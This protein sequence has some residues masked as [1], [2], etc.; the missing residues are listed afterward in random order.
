MPEGRDGE[1]APDA[2][3]AAPGAVHRQSGTH[4]VFISYASSDR[5]VADSVCAALERAGVNCW[6][7]PRD[8]TPGEF[9]SEAIVHAID[10]AKVVVL[11]LSQNAAVS[12][13]VLRE[14]ERASSKR[15]PVVSFRID[16]AP[17]PA[18]L[19]YFL[20]TSQWLDASAIG[21]ERALPKLVDAVQRGVAHTSDS[22][23]SPYGG[24]RSAARTE[25]DGSVAT[26]MRQRSRLMLLALAA[27]TAVALAYLVVDQFWLSKRVDEQKFSEAATPY[28]TGESFGGVSGP[29]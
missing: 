13:H 28:P 17:L 1:Q 21:V 22:A 25:P 29:G 18:A 6:I 19:E 2:A 11:I 3:L 8:V 5:A 4:T 10:S 7:A 16:L 24:A 12:Q 9:Y 20:N 14:V 23:T 26:Q 27:L 15:H